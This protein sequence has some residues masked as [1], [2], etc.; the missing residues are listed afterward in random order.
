MSP[1]PIKFPLDPTGNSPGN[2]VK[3]E[4]KTLR[5]T[6]TRIFATQYG[7]F[8]TESL[9]VKDTATNR[10]L[11]RNVD[12]FATEMY[13]MP[14]EMFGKEICAVVVITDPTCG[15]NISV[16][17]QALGGEFSYS[18]D[19]IIQLI[20]K[21]NLDNRP[22]EWGNIIDKPDEFQ[23]APHLHDVGDVYG[24]E[25]LV[26]AIE[27]VSQAIQLGSAA[28][29]SKIYSYLDSQVKQLYTA[30]NAYASQTQTKTSIIN[31]LG[32][33]PADSRGDTFAG[34]VTV[35]GITLSGYLKEGIV[36]VDARGSETVLDLSQGS[37]FFVSVYASS[38][39]RFDTSKIA[40]LQTDQSISFTVVLVN[41]VA[42][43]GI[44]FVN[45]VAWSGGQT[46]PRTVT[47]NGRDEYYFSTFNSGASYTGSLS[48]QDVK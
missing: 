3:G 20:S 31:A 12:Y 21:L 44:S 6:K 8:Y 5:N 14:T 10:V 26:G 9:V 18:Y 23:P 40:D 38:G 24:M 30:L 19:A 35:P 2:Y 7:P 16:D 17:Y 22:V 25:Y 47:L 34:P 11:T 13:Q 48:D 27:R 29:E 28:G 42:N 33:R 41:V 1:V 45:T 37:I 46:P 4:L 15:S 36:K 32:Y 43:A 39:I